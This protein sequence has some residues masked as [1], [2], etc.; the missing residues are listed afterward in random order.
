MYTN[1]MI[2]VD[3]SGESLQAV[4]EALH[5][6]ER[7]LRA[8]VALVNVQEPASLLQLATQDSDAI[9]AA[10]VEAGENLMGEAAALLNAA[11]VNY[12]MEVVL[13]EPGAA[14]VDMAEQLDADMVMM[15]ARGM[16]AVKSVIVGSVSKA[17][18]THIGRPVLVVRAPEEGEAPEDLDSDAEDAAA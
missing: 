12:S 1:I 2:A 17:V 4:R 5:L 9:A 10:A 3:G 6:I 16:G 8:E 11:G 18:I 13:G 7:G 15:G 14:L